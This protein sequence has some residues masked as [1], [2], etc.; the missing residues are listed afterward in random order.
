MSENENSVYQNL[1][2]I[3][4]KAVFSE[5]FIVVN[6]YIRNQVELEVDSL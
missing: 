1:W 4:V 3:T 6:A 5:K 2:D